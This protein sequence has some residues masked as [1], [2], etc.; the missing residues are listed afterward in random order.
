MVEIAKLLLGW[1]DHFVLF[2]FLVFNSIFLV[3]VLAGGAEVIRARRQ[4]QPISLEEVF[5]Y[6]L[7]PDVSVVVPAFD[8]ELTIIDSVHGMLNLRYPSHEVVVVDDGSTDRTF[9]LLDNEFDLEP[10]DAV[11]DPAIRVIGS[12]FAS[13]RSRVDPRLI[14]VRKENAQTRSDAVNAGLAV[15]TKTLVCMTDADSIFDPDALLLVA[16]AYLRDP[17]RTVGIGGTIRAING[18]SVTRG[19]LEDAKAPAT[20]TARIQVVEYLRSFLLGRVAWSRLKALIIVSGAFGVYRRELLSELGGL[21]P[22]A[23]AEDAELVVRV[24]KH[25][26]DRDVDYRLAFLPDPVC[27]T[28]VPNSLSQ[29]AK[30]RRRWSRGLAEVLWLHR[31]MLFNPR[32]GRIGLV[33]LPYYLMFELFGAIIEF[34]GVGAVLLGFALDLINTRMA[35]IV[36]VVALLY[37]MVLS[38]ITILIEEFSYRRYTRPLDLLNVALAGFIEITGFRQIHAFWRTHGLISA[39]RR[40]ESTWEKPDRE[41][42]GSSTEESPAMVGSAS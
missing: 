34:V 29:L 26:R 12:I 6:P 37:A 22:T 31:R 16:R 5:A 40:S 7:T 21:D 30:Q 11:I 14:V 17:E 36:A 18:S 38:A 9:E 24:H 35:I 10:F 33:A 8:E 42:F 13:Y 4:V 3:L 23:L 20:W 25:M 32:Y 39:L 2:Y 28:E 27:W 1:F 15:A 19:H 41:G